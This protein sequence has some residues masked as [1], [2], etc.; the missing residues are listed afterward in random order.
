MF[1]SISTLNIDPNDQ[2]P[3][4]ICP[5]CYSIL[6]RAYE[7]QEMCINSDKEMRAELARISEISE[8]QPFN[9]PFKDDPP[10]ANSMFMH[11]GQEVVN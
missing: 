11:D 10:E 9:E 6:L 2:L 5:S 3:D 8:C 1:S 4:L 7:F